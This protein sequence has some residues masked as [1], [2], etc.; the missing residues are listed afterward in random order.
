ML[1]AL[2][3]LVAV[4]DDTATIDRGND[5]NRIETETGDITETADQAISDT[6]AEGVHGILDNA[7]AMLACDSV[8]ALHIAGIPCEVQRYNGPGAFC[9]QRLCLVRINT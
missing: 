3:L 1:Q 9:Y 6:G 7:Q 5:L 4:N 8:Y 2:L